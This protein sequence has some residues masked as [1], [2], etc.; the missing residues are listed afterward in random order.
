MAI[1]GSREKVIGENEERISVSVRLRPLNDDEVLSNEVCDWECINDDTIVFKNLD[2]GRSMHHHPMAYTF[3][4]VFGTDCST[5]EVY[6]HGAKDV[7]IS[8]VRGINSTV[9][10]Y[11]QKSS[12][13]TYTMTGITEYAIADIYEYIK[14]HSNRDFILKFSAIEIYNESVRDLLGSDST[15]LRLLDDLEGGTIVEN[16]TEEILRDRNHANELLC[17]CRAQRNIRDTSLNEISSGTH[18]IIRVTVES[19]SREFLGSNNTTTLAATVNFVDLAAS[20]YASQ[21]LS[22][23]RMGS[24]EVCHINRSLIT[25]GTVIHKLSKDPNGHIPY[26]DS[27]LTQILKTSLG[28]NSRTAIICTISPTRSQVD[29][30]RKAL[31]F[32]SHAKE[33]ATKSQVNVVMSDKTLVSHLQKELARL[34]RELKNSRNDVGL[35]HYYAML[36]EKDSQIEK[37]EKEIRDLILQRDIA[38]SQVKEFIQ[39]LGDD[40]SSMTQVGSGHYPHLRVQKSDSD[41]DKQESSPL[42]DPT[43]DVDNPTFSNR[44]STSSPEDHVKVPFFEDSF[45]HGYTSPR[46]LLS[47]S[48][49]SVSESYH[50]WPETEER[51]SRA[52]PPSVRIEERIQT[53]EYEVKEDPPS[54]EGRA[55][56]SPA[57]DKNCDF[58]T[59]QYLNKDSCGGRSLN[60]ARSNSC[61][62]SVRSDSSSLW[63]KSEEYGG[64][65]TPAVGLDT[66]MVSSDAKFPAGEGGSRANHELSEKAELLS[67]EEINNGPETEVVTQKGKTTED[68]CRGLTSWPVEFRRLQREIIELWNACNISLLHRTYFFLLFQG[69]PSDAIY[70]EVEMRRMKL[71]RDKFSRGDK[72]V[73]DGRTLT[74]S[75]S[76]K[77]LRQERRTLSE[78]MSKK[79]SEQERENLFTEWGIGLNT[80]LRRLQL[81]RLVWSKT[82]DI[83]HVTE[84]AFL[85]AKLVGLI[86]P[87]QAPNREMFG[88]NFTH[89][90]STGIS[91]FKRSLVSLL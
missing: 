8:V 12:G 45:D 40:A 87:G 16:L 54:N 60:L 90:C 53:D 73:V 86:E 32:A 31:V 11:G 89:K 25:L 56:D 69:D 2:S 47:S 67:R 4:S 83:N 79:F 26:G 33:V 38:Q 59:I 81:A 74:L 43:L 41:V 30:S 18:H 37:L 3:D 28:G 68:E 71:L 29:Q 6:E 51:A 78:Q 27:K 15:P 84:S 24:K 20:E 44:H 1:T 50:I 62:A 22:S 52:S 61:R 42:A 91:T 14:K 66:K 7:A 5:R 77:A 13:K 35:S 19:S 63:F 72:A 82:E 17:I 80:K 49:S 64:D 34:E 85:V 55:P 58:S 23:A 48:N 65:T 88:L 70:L 9:F 57:L 36:R 46:I 10:A 75:S 21:L 39:I 76:A